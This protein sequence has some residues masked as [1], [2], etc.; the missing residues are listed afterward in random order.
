MTK[1][2]KHQDCATPEEIVS[3]RKLAGLTQAEAAAMLGYT[4][5]TVRR[6]EAGESKMRRVLLDQL[7]RHV[8]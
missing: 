1:T 5:R 8:A 7:K 4:E 3:A 6:W 2:L